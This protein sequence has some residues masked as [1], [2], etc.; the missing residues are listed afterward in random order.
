MFI[1]VPRACGVLPL[2]DCG[3]ARVP[4]RLLLAVDTEDWRTFAALARSTS[5][6]PTLSAETVAACREAGSL[7]T[8][9]KRLPG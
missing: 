7:L 6:A 8:E 1:R 5:T 9:W 2:T 3:C 4:S